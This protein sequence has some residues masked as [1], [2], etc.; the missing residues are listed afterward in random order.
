MSI[1]ENPPVRDTIPDQPDAAAYRLV[2]EDARRDLHHSRVQEWSALGVVAGAH[3]AIFQIAKLLKDAVPDISLPGL[4][5]IA[6]IVAGLFAILGAAITLRHRRLMMV[7]LNWIFQAEDS[8]GLI[9]DDN[10]STGI[11]PREGSVQHPVKWKGV[12]VPR[13]LS[14][15]FLIL[16]FYALLLTIDIAAIVIFRSM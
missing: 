9:K 11:I 4:V 1:D 6:A 15:S 14:T 3:F 13:P 5:A 2:I 16:A 8:L 10:S 12:N 7:K